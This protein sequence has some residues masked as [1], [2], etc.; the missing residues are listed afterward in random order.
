MIEEA[1]KVVTE[2]WGAFAAVMATPIGALGIKRIF[3]TYTK[4]DVH[5]IID[6]K[7]DPLH[8]LIDRN[9]QTLERTNILLTDVRIKMAER[10]GDDRG[11]RPNTG[12]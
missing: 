11:D 12:G 6:A 7:V 8:E 1:G 4:E 10:R 9:T 5:R 3:N 2:W